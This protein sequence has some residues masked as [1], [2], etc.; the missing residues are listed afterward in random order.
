MCCVLKRKS[1]HSFKCFK[2]YKCI[3][4]TV[5][6][7]EANKF[8]VEGTTLVSPAV[9]AN[10]NIRMYAAAPAAVTGVD[11]WQMEFN[12]FDGVIVYRAGGGDQAA[13]PATAG[14]KATLDFNA[15]TGS[16]N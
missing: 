1:R 15:G 9:A 16:I 13:S 12:V 5:V 14:Q 2:A 10:N 8:T 6:T 4:N 3:V 7:V 11:W